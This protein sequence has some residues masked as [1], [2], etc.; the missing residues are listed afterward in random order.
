MKRIITILSASAILAA[1]CD[2]NVMP[3]PEKEQEN[4]E[5]LVPVSLKIDGINTKATSAN[6]NEEKIN[7]LQVFVYTV[8]SGQKTFDSYYTFGTEDER[9]IYINSADKTVSYW[10]AA[11]ANQPEIESG[12][13]LKDWALFAN[14][15]DKS[16]Q[17][18]GKTE[19]TAEAILRD[20][21]VKIDLVRQCSKVTVEEIAVQWTNTANRHKTFILKG[22]Y[23]MDVPGVFA[24]FFT[25]DQTVL[26]NTSLWQNQN[27]H[28]STSH[29]ALLYDEIGDID[30]SETK[31]YTADH[32]FYGYLSPL[33]TY[34]TDATWKPGGTR[35][36]IEAEFD[37]KACYYA[38]ALN[39]IETDPGTQEK[40][41]H[42]DLRNMHIIFNKITITRPGAEKPYLALP[43]ESPITVSVSVKPWQS[44]YNGNYI[45]Q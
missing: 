4:A 12:Q 3:A 22:M 19:M 36:V 40:I 39:G 30:V 41:T 26:D 24:N 28:T 25:A 9:T 7:D 10:I 2:S 37:G 42:S 23:L 32:I 43:D 29:D 44:G 16:F 5:S 35:L 15:S 20:K 45:I 18:A 1:S 31:A 38:V 14:E 27:G 6:S 34:N 13:T 11:Y 33:T 21:E 8:N 17:M